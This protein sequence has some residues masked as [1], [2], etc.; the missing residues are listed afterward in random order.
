MFKRLATSIA[1]SAEKRVEKI[2]PN[3]R[4]ATFVRN[5]VMKSKWGQNL[6]RELSAPLHFIPI[7]K[8]KIQTLVD[9]VD[10]RHFS[11]AGG[12]KK[13]KKKMNTKTNKHLHKN[14]KRLRRSKHSRK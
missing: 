13:T 5:K 11:H 8:P 10:Y 9:S 1:A 4:F 3:G 12:K 14:K 6:E 2:N 7:Q